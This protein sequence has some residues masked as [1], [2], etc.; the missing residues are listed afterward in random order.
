MGGREK[1]V[2]SKRRILSPLTTSAVSARKI[3]AIK[4]RMMIS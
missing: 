2:K 3:V 4:K 1:T